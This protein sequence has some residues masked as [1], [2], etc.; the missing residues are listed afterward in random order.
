[1]RR[2][3]LP[4]R[5]RSVSFSVR[6]AII[7]GALGALVA[8]GSIAIALT[9]G[10][11]QARQQALDRSADRVGVALNLL[12]D[13]SSSLSSFAANTGRQL[14]APGAPGD[15][16]S[17]QRYLDEL[18]ASTTS[19]D[20][21]LLSS[22]TRVLA[23]SGGRT[24]AASAP[25]V[26]T[27]ARATGGQAG[28]VA[29]PDGAATL[30]ESATL[31]QPGSWVVIGRH[32]DATA[33][34]NLAAQ[35]GTGADPTDLLL[36]HDGRVAVATSFDGAALGAGAPVPSAVA[37]VSAGDAAVAH[38]NRDDVAVAAVSLGAGYTLV[39]ASVPAN[40]DIFTGVAGPIGL[41]GAAV[42]VL[43]LVIVF[44]IVEGEVQG[45]L[46][47]LDRAV[48]ALARGD[49]EAP[50]PAHGDNEIG[51]LGARFEAM[52]SQLRGVLESAH[53]RAEIGVQLTATEPLGAAVDEVCERLRRTTG[54]AASLVVLDRADDD[55]E[56]VH[57][58]GLR[59][60]V[61]ALSLL[62]GEGVVAAAARLPRIET[63]LACSLA[64]SAERACGMREICA[65]P[66]RI[67]TDTVGVIALADKRGGFVSNDGDLLTAAAEQVAL[68]VL[69]DRVLSM[70]RHQ[71]STDGLTGLYNYRFLID[72][73][74]RQVAVADRGHSAL[75]VL[76]LDLDRFKALNDAH[77]HQVGDEALRIFARTLLGSIR[78]SDLAARYGGEEF[79][80]VM[81]N[82]DSSEARVV[83][84]KIRTN[85]AAISLPVEGR[86]AP[87]RFTVSI[88]GA[89]YPVDAIQIQPL[90][91]QADAA[92]YRAKAEGRNRVCFVSDGV[93]RPVPKK[94]ASNG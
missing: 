20:T 16:A 3:G 44:V 29:A 4:G 92:M 35:L 84:E 7:L 61:D 72:Y 65:A 71:A 56:P 89:A 2:P 64:G 8:L 33:V 78:R 82:T 26:V 25:M 54:S 81:S 23:A 75:S 52:R 40:V 53:T 47:S 60:G 66:L 83:A 1:M 86:T 28:I 27:L 58:S 9:A 18:S 11:R 10:S 91:G 63:L 94:Q 36:V 76:M 43:I 41:L 88:G 39:A 34:R 90:L 93:A 19:Q 68:A 5:R 55:T 87:I 46:R 67:G 49:F 48:E 62:T 14:D 85:V 15:E 32:V 79:V 22:P 21:V 30:V 57:L 80:V 13:Q 38:G 6:F 59:S 69:R 42:V 37:Q 17:Q 31:S 45:P 12:R 51:R 77:G 74:E 73:L 50:V 24:L 70:A